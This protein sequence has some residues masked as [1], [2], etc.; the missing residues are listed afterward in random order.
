MYRFLVF[1][2]SDPKV[3]HRCT[4]IGSCGLFYQCSI[5]VF[6]DHEWRGQLFVLENPPRIVCLQ[7]SFIF[8]YKYKTKNQRTGTNEADISREQMWKFNISSSNVVKLR[9]YHISSKL[10]TGITYVIHTWCLEI[11]MGSRNVRQEKPLIIVLLISKTIDLPG[12]WHEFPEYARVTMKSVHLWTS[13]TI[14]K[15]LYIVFISE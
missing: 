6:T 13:T 10:W 14:N 5:P 15:L 11:Q 8:V 3:A 7:E 4:S 9:H 12:S 2:F 1:S